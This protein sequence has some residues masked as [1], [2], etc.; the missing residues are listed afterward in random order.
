MAVVLLLPMCAAAQSSSI[1]AYSPYSMFG[2]GELHTPGTIQMR[3]MGGV[4]IGLRS[5]GQ[6]NLLNPA[7]ASAAMSKTFLFD[8]GFDG[9][10]YR[11]SQPK[12]TAE[13]AH[14]HTARTVYNGVNVHSLAMV[15]P[16]AKGMGMTFSVAPYS[17]VGYM[18]KTTDQQQNNW[19]DI[20]R[21]MYGHTGDGDITEV[22]LAWGWAPWRTFSVGVAAKYYWGNITRGYTAEVV[23][24]IT[25]T[26]TYERLL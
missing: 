14:S 22:R 24:N 10:H 2:P 9:T 3:S 16:V 7:S 4:G 12:Y 17:S 21:V 5:V 19:A 6:I 20:G 18:M 23:N 26:G 11:N 25:G 1:N 8:M 13:G 15:F